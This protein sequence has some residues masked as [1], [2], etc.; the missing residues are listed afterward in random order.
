[1]HVNFCWL[2]GMFV[3]PDSA[4]WGHNWQDESISNVLLWLVETCQQ[5]SG[6]WWDKWSYRCVP[7]DYLHP[8][9]LLLGDHI[10]HFELC[11][12][13]QSQRPTTEPSCLMTSCQLTSS[14]GFW[15]PVHLQMAVMHLST[16]FG[17]KN[18]SKQSRDFDIFH[19]SVWQ[20]FPSICECGTFWHGVRL[21]LELYTKF[22]S[23]IC[24]SFWD[25]S[26]F[27]FNV[28]L[29]TSHELTSGFLWSC[30]HLYMA[31]LHLPA[32]L[33][34]VNL[35]CFQPFRRCNVN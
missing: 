18:I 13:H 5:M 15:S 10:Q 22:S 33:S 30:S 25:Q 34:Y 20:P 16:K 29:M 8:G 31:L 26:P 19:N 28:R 32:K 23:N 27:V 35:A 2:W 24:Y 7:Q 9:Y 11:L 17:K 12:A 6:C 1:M 4:Q 14:F 21:M 3:A